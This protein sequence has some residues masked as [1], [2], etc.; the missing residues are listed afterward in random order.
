MITV[1]SNKWACYNLIGQERLQG[2]VHGGTVRASVEESIGRKEVNINLS[3]RKI[4][5]KCSRTTTALQFC[6]SID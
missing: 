6:I 4:Y 2:K 1:C 3:C 5:D